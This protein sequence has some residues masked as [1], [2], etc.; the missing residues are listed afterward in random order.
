MN[1]IGT[2]TLKP[3]EPGEA[4]SLYA[5]RPVKNNEKKP[6]MQEFQSEL[7]A[8]LNAPNYGLKNA[9]TRKLTEVKP[10]EYPEWLKI[11]DEF[12]AVKECQRKKKQ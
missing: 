10:K 4:D 1:A 11:F 12:Q 2:E 5:E 7:T 6:S 8:K 3:V 9:E